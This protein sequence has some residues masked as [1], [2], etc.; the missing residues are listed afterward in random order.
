MRIFPLFLLLLATILSGSSTCEFPLGPGILASQNPF[1]AGML[2]ATDLDSQPTEVL[3]NIGF[4]V[5]DSDTYRTPLWVCYRL[6]V[7][8]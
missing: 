6:F 3:K 8:C 4:T 5:G 7:T 1:Y 2:L